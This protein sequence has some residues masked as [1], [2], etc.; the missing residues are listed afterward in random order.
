MS[1]R[2]AVAGCTGYAGGEVLRLLLGHPEVNIGTLTGNSSV[3]DLLGQHQPH[4]AALANREI[5][6]TSAENLAGHD[7]VFLALPH[8][9]S[10]AIAEQLGEDVL[11]VDA[12]ADF[13]LADA[14]QWRQFYGTAHAGTWPYGLPELPGQREQLAGTKRVAVPGCYPTASTLALLPA[15]AGGLIDTSD[16]SIVAVS[17][18]SGAGKSL[19]PNL[20]G[21]EVM[22]NVSPYGVGGTHRHTPEI[23]QNLSRVSETEVSVSFTP[24]LAPLPRGILATCSAPIAEGVTQEMAY[25]AY[26]AQYQ[27]EPFVELLPAGTLPTT[28]SVLAS[29]RASVQVV[30]DPAA[31]R[32][33]AFCAIDNLTKGTAG[34]AIQSMNLALGISEETGLTTNGVAP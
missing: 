14:N 22:G 25:Q 10:A 5:L 19:K 1:I 3:G 32:L 27:A 16:I 28:A 29:N 7:V 30:L 34:G 31:G 33:V 23:V 11:V 12:G 15:V 17:G 24:V 18:T 21:S 20:L 13:R 2:V 8:G 9:T 6:A 4:L 26:S